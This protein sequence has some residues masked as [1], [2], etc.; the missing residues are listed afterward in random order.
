M[1]PN[2]MHRLYAK[3]AICDWIDEGKLDE[4]K[5]LDDHLAHLLGYRDYEHLMLQQDEAATHSLIL[6]DGPH[7]LTV[8]KML[9]VKWSDTN[10]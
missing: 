6:L 7:G 5:N 4:I 8:Y 10:G 2:A 9:M 1:Q 3:A